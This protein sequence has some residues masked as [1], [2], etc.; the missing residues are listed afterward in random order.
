M[1]GRMLISPAVAGFRKIHSPSRWNHSNFKFYTRVV[2]STDISFTNEE[3]GL[4]NKG[5]QYNLDHKHKIRINNLAMETESALSLLPPGEQEYTGHQIAKNIK[6][7]LNQQNSQNGKTSLK[8]KEEFRLLTQIKEKLHRNRTLITKADKGNTV[9]VLYRKEYE[10]VV[11]NFISDIEAV[12][13]NENIT[14][15]FRKDLRMAL[16]E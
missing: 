8:G 15:K 13:A 14:D 7:L 11:K 12:E 3:L 5:L 2:N 10:R 6:K 4:L 1:F 16:N 9:V